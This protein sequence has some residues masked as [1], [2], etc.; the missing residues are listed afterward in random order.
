MVSSSPIVAQ[1]FGRK[2][3]FALSIVGAGSGAGGL[4]FSNLNRYL[5]ERI[6]LQWT[7]RIKWAV[8]RLVALTLRSGMMSI[9]VL[10][11][12]IVLVRGRN[13]PLKTRFRPFEYQLF[14]NP[15]FCTL[16]SWGVFIRTSNV[17]VR[18]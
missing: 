6:S 9:G 11:P 13:K 18:R 10:L 8:P 16:V 3:A 14:S 17:S 2:R 15:G 4:L 12:C 7:Y 5:I 1:W